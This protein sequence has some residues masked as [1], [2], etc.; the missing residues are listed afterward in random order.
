MSLYLAMAVDLYT[1]YTSWK[2]LLGAFPTW[3]AGCSK[4][5]TEAISAD[6]HFSALYNKV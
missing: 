1:H 5:G 2:L 6:S 4:T 3:E